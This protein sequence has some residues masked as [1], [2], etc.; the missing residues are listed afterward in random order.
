MF[1]A[2]CMR[3]MRVCGF[4]RYRIKAARMPG[5][6]FGQTHGRKHSAFQGAVLIYRF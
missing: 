2:A 4:L 6:A 3:G 5:M 1:A